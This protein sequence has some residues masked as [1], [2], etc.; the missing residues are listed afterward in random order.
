[1][2]CLSTTTQGTLGGHALAL[3]L[4]SKTLSV[5]GDLDLTNVYLIPSGNASTQGSGVQINLGG[6][7]NAIGEYTSIYTDCTLNGRQLFGYIN[8]TNAAT[9]TVVTR[10]GQARSSDAWDVSSAYSYQVKPGVFLDVGTT[11][12]SAT[13]AFIWNVTNFAGSTIRVANAGGLE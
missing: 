4:S 10:S 3:S 2:T 5:G 11:P 12:S 9:G 1:V 13:E 6:N 8:L 7:I